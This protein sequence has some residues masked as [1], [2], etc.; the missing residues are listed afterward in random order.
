[1]AAEGGS[2][3]HSGAWSLPALEEQGVIRAGR[4]LHLALLG[5]QIRCI[6]QCSCG[7]ANCLTALEMYIILSAAPAPPSVSS[8][9]ARDK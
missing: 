7:R 1:M 3:Q 5:K 4:N 6:L 2:W 8:P 9:M